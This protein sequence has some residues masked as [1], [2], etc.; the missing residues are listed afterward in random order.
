MA[1][2]IVVSNRL[3]ITLTKDEVKEIGKALVERIKV[4]AALGEPLFSI[5]VKEEQT[6]LFE[7]W[8]VEGREPV[9]NHLAKLFQ[10]DPKN[11]ALF[12][13][14][15]APRTWGQEDVLPRVGELDGDQL[16]NIKLIFDLDAL[17]DLIQKHLPGDFANP[18]WF[19]DS[20]KP[21]EQRLAEQFIVV[22]NNLKKKGEP[23]DAGSKD[24][25]TPEADDP[26]KDADTDEEN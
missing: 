6:L 9:Q 14:A 3:P 25:S 15:M 11:I 18:Q 1:R 10:K 8:R 20:T 22:Y 12:L 17:A 21:I 4:K 24:E 5:D 26:I 13:Q 23:P 16:K 19:P 2:L 7:W